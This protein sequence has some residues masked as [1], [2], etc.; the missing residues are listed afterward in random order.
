MTVQTASLRRQIREAA[1]LE[2]ARRSLIHFVKRVSEAPGGYRPDAVHYRLC[3]ALERFSAAVARG[4]SPRLLVSM[5]PRHG[6]TEIV[7]K[8]WPV[9]HMARHRDHEF[10]S[11][12]YGQELADDNSR[13]ARQIARGERALEVF[14]ELMPKIPEKRYYADYR[15]ADVDK[16]G[17]WRVGTGS[18]YKAVGVGGPLTGRGA[19]IL[20]I[21]DPFKD[22]ADAD[23]AV[24][25]ERVWGW[26]A[27]TAYTRL[28][29]GGGVIV[30]ATRWHEEDLIGMLREA[31]AKG[32]GDKWEI[33]NLPA[34][35]EEDEP[36][37]ERDMEAARLYERESGR[38]LPVDAQGRLCW[39]LEGEALHPRRFPLER[40][41]PIRE[42]VTSRGGERE[43]AALYQCRP[44]PQGGDR[45]KREWFR[46]RYRC[47]PEEIAQQADEVWLSIDAAKKG[48]A[49]SDFHSLQVWAWNRSTG[50]R[51]VLDRI[52]S[53]M[54]Y[55]EFERAAD[56][57]IARWKYWLAAKGGALIEDTA[58]GTTYLQVRG[59]AYL[60]VALV[61]F[62]PNK[63]TPGTDKSKEARAVY[64]ERPAE[65][66]AIVLPDPSIAP[67]VEDL[68]TWWCGFPLAAKDDDVDSASQINMRWTLQESSGASAL[69]D[70]A[71][72]LGLAGW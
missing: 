71:R 52:S 53:R 23:S 36:V 65:A 19:H 67:W 48:H 59:P 14:P 37:D 34:I 4:E 16:V 24:Q 25:R 28:A 57:M 55:P 17:H 41:G 44:V 35:A 18:S 60:G 45:I 27:S 13:A 64:L 51:Y 63:D 49:K 10:V 15:R 72:E 69:D 22:R 54:G 6:K 20:D 32:R 2:L 70:F 21:D 66:G 40:L 58:N 38:G 61:A 26:Y 1:R 39:R 12:S 33:I 68:L 11:A 8:C 7:S 47:A 42:A 50:K 9:W 30:M 31:Q 46:E 29:P 56:G 43:W 62:H 5:P 3:A